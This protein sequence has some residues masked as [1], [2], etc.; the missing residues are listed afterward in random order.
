[1][2]EDELPRHIRRERDRWRNF[3]R[4]RPQSI[5]EPGPDQ[6]SVWDYPRPP[7]LEPVAHELRVELGGVVIAHTRQGYRACETSSPPTYYF[8]PHDVRRD[9]LLSEARTTLCEWKGVASYWSL[10]VE[11]RFAQHAVW[12]YPEPWRGFEA[13]AHYFAFDASMMDGCHV[14]GEK[15]RAQPGDYYGGWITDDLVGPFKG[16]PGTEH[17]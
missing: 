8:P 1:M 9:L 4:A 2:R 17:W 14:G 6:E 12:A 15:V 3:S 10:R 5:A 7:R 11:Q 13:I 16:E